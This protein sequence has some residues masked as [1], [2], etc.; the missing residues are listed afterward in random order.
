MKTPND[1]EYLRTVDRVLDR[2]IAQ[3]RQVRVR[4][5]LVG[6]DVLRIEDHIVVT[7]LERYLEAAQALEEAIEQDSLDE[8]LPDASPSSGEED[9]IAEDDQM[10]L[11]GD[12]LPLH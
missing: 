7:S 11:P 1:T 10:Q 6:A 12:S 3:R 4:L 8:L 9:S 2:G 5:P